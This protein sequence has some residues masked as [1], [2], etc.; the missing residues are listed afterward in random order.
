MFKYGLDAPTV[1]RNCA[2]G[3]FG[4]LM[5]LVLNEV[6]IK[7]LSRPLY[8]VTLFSL[9]SSLLGLL[10]PIFTIIRGSLSLK[11]RE[12]DWLFSHLELNGNERVLDVGCGQGL[13][14]IEAAKKMSTGMVYGI[15]IWSTDDQSNNSLERTLEQAKNAGVLDNVSLITA[16]AE[17]L[18]F[19]RDYFEVII[20]SFALHNISSSEARER[21]LAEIDRCLQ[22]GGKIALLDLSFIDEY[23]HYF[24]RLGYITK[25]LG[26][27]YTFG[28][29]TYLLYGEKP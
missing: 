23:E 22:S 29:K 20:S 25:K 1:V 4:I 16:N 11:F 28:T 21:A 17:E 19:E 24:D 2:I 26:P 10:Y 5:G 9:V 8:L 13:L 7:E 15:D 6:Y 3:V 18:P 12:R 14:L 27:R